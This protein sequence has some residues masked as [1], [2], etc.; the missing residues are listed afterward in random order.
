MHKRPI[1]YLALAFLFGSAGS[2]LL[3]APLAAPAPQDA[4]T[5]ESKKKPED[6]YTKFFKDKKVETAKGK[7]VT[8]HKMDGDVYLELPTKL[9][10]QELMMGA[11]ITSTT[12]PDYLAVGSK[13]SA[14]IVFRIEQ[15]DSLLVMKTPNTLVYKRG[16]SKELS[17][18]LALNYRDPIVE[19]FKP[20]VYRADSSAVVIKLNKLIT[21]T[22]PFFEIMPKQQGPFKIT[23]TRNNAL[24]FVRGLKSFD[25]NASVRVEMNFS[26][27]A[28]LMG[29]LTVARDMPLTAEVTYTLLPV[30]ASTAIPRFADA[31][32]G[33]ET[34]RKV[35]FPEYLDQSEPVYLAH[36]WNLVPKNKSAYAA[37]KLSEPEKKIIFYLDN[38]L[39]AGWVKPVREG[40]LRWNKAFESAGF[41]DVI[42][43]RDFPKN[44]KHFDPDNLEYSCIRFVPNTMETV[45]S[46]SWSDPRTGEIFSAGLT[47]YNNVASQLYKERFL[48]TAA[49]DPTIRS[50]QL[51]QAQLE[52]SLSLLVSQE[53][54]R[55]LGLLPNQAASAAYTIADLRSSKSQS[56]GLAASI[57]DGASYNY[58][59]QPT[60]KG[61]RLVND[62]LGP[63]DHYAI[64][65]GYTYFP[66]S[67]GDPVA[68]AKLLTAMV[69]KQAG[70]ARYRFAPE[71][72]YAIDPTVREQDLGDAPLQASALG[73]K[74]LAI[75]RN[76]LEQWIKNDPDSRK[77]NA[78]YLGVAQQ[79]YLMLKNGMSLVGGIVCTT[80]R[81]SS[82]QPSYR[83]IPKTKQREAFLWT[84]EQA[85]QFQGYA[86]R[87][88][89]RRGFLNI[90]YFDQL[91]EFIVNDILNL[92]ARIILASQID[93]QSYSLEE[94][95]DDLY[96][97]TFA[98]TIAGKNP[99]HMERLMQTAFVDKSVSG[100]KSA[101][102]VTPI[103]P[104]G[105]ATPMLQ[106]PAGQLSASVATSAD[107]AEALQSNKASFR[108]SNPSA[109]IYPM[110]NVATVD[111]SDRYMYA[112][113]LKLRP[114]LE[115]RIASTSDKVL[116]AHY[117]TLAFKVARLLDE[118]K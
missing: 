109:S 66:K 20:E 16:A 71:T 100:A 21:E 70:D 69:N 87:S 54:G 2:T 116:R 73:M 62:H 118:K 6:K 25:T 81:L 57:L 15:Q 7:F 28:S 76:G 97:A 94:Y 55:V 114:L 103:F 12:D 39:P 47:I 98:A 31:R 48:A 13:N 79:Y 93:K 64:S 10:G 113:L 1:R 32:V 30:Q 63:Y 117:Q 99:N 42:E 67:G 86:D 83:V 36:R 34:S 40:V 44:D 19:S 108:S 72:R 50:G 95:F 52:Q 77:K 23:S 110:I 91:L 51:S 53:V 60:D 33:Y 111:T 38:T 41:K 61:A 22:N 37:G 49:V 75:I 46:S 59:A 101:R 14:P 58:L 105:F 84:L 45:S 24:T 9:L 74:N 102:A 43:V 4:K 85:K 96:Q 35:S 88:L 17:Q 8:L 27:T 5:S 78:L 104:T 29:L 18:A 56:Q 106:L 3:A 89:E 82:G 65:W 92:R 80:P 68:E 107:Y 26:V 115:K 112:A 11:T 90:G